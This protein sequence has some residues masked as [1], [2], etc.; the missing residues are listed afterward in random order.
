MANVPQR[1]LTEQEYLEIERSLA[2]KNE[3]FRGEMFA[4]TGAS[5]KHNLIS[6]NIFRRIHEQFDGRRCEVYTNDM[7]IKINSSGLYT[8]PDIVATCEDPKFEDAEV[9]TL[10]NP[11]VIFEVLSPSTE[12]YDRSIKFSHYKRLKSLRAYIIVSQNQPFVERYLPQPDGQWLQWV[13]QEL[14]DELVIDCIDCKLK[15]SDIYDRIEFQDPGMLREH[16]EDFATTR[17][18]S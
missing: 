1:Q 7:R 14:V 10:I 13:S 2:T 11:Q 3:Y 17:P 16:Y 9:D 15:L 6:G 12:K 8:Y 5:R 18:L 4:M